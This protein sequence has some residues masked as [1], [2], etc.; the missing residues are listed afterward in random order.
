MNLDIHPEAQMNEGFTYN[1]FDD[2]TQS[3]FNMM[4][5]DSD[6]TPLLY[7]EVN[8]GPKN[9]QKLIVFDGENA[10]KVVDA[11]AEKHKLTE[12]K[13]LRLTKVVNDQLSIILPRIDETKEEEE[14]GFK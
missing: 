7:L 11:F 12:E 3:I 6:K 5:I 8:L 10:K 9:L 1:I 13:K 2:S 14:E 4:N